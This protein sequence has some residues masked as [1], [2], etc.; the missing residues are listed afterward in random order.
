MVLKGYTSRI[1]FKTGII[2]E[3]LW[4]FYTH[5]TLPRIWKCGDL[6]AKYMHWYTI[7]YLYLCPG[8]CTMDQYWY[9]LVDFIAVL[10]YFLTELFNDGSD[11]FIDGGVNLTLLTLI[12]L[13]YF[14]ITLN[15]L[16]LHKPYWIDLLL[17][18]F[19]PWWSF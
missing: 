4:I 7:Y 6:S 12:S 14:D 11:I 8:I 13:G 19:Q 2:I 16:T 17:N 10:M 1:Y 5:L 9:I 3:I 18:F 15:L